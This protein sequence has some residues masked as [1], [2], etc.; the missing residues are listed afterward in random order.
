[1][2]DTPQATPAITPPPGYTLDTPAPQ[3]SGIKPPPGYTLD[4]PT[5]TTPPAT[6]AN[7]APGAHGTE[8]AWG[9]IVGVGKGLLKTAA[10]AGELINNVVPALMYPQVPLGE[11]PKVIPDSALKTAESASETKTPAESFGSG[12]E[13]L[14]EF[15]TGDELLAGISR[16]AELEKLAKSSPIIAKMIEK[17]PELFKKIA[18]G[19]T[20][21][22]VV[23]GAQ[24]AVKGAAEGDAAGGAKGGAIGGAAGGAAAETVSAVAKPIANKMGIATE[25]TEDI[26]R[27]AKPGKRN[28]RFLADWDTAK[29]EYAK[30]LD[31]NGSY[32]DY[33]DAAERMRSLRQDF[34]KDKVAPKIAAHAN[35]QVFPTNVGNAPQ[36]GQSQMVFSNPI[37]DS[38]RSKIT[39][40]MK[41]LDPKAEKAI[42]TIAKR[43]DGTRTV[44]ELEDDIEHLNAKLS[45]KDG[46]YSMTASERAAALKADPSIAATVAA[47]EASRD[48]LT[49]YLEKAGEKDI[50]E[51]KRMYGA[52]RNVENE[53]RG[54][55]N[56][57]GRQNP[58][59][60]KQIIGIASG[61]PI[62]I[63]ATLLDKI[64]NDPASILERAV[65]KNIPDGPV[66]SAVKDIVSGAGTVAKEAIPAAGAAV[67]R[68][69]FVGSDGR[70][71]NAP[72][73]AWEKVQQADPGAK[74]VN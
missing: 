49:S 15:A 3:A 71:Y 14:A 7:R 48:Q 38:I 24:G 25:D 58:I 5:Q 1:M 67:G 33:N 60:L 40:A 42:E 12:I 52:M 62:G 20:K 69:T 36:P 45:L 8:G 32:E 53:V 54:Q 28:D 16:V 46:Y 31:A 41:R 74:Q 11:G 55:V 6:N 29:G 2:A 64:Y 22:A 68:I 50:P 19:T 73:S 18:T 10:G 57:Q 51:L 56:V 34:W 13:N 23:G 21:G 37:S 27:A 4:A 65:R 35:E 43:F 17:T 39:P 61:H 26:M 70:K 47:V 66:K 63:A 44:K 30:E 72:A 59:S 9:T